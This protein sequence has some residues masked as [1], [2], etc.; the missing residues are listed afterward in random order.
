MKKDS[1][2]LNIKGCHA[3]TVLRL[4]CFM[5]LIHLFYHSAGIIR[6]VLLWLMPMIQMFVWLRHIST[7]GN[8][9]N[10]SLKVVE[11]SGS[12]MRQPT[13]A[14][15]PPTVDSCSY[16]LWKTNDILINHIVFT[17]THRFIAPHIHIILWFCWVGHDTVE[18]FEPQVK[19][20]K[21][22]L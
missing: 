13:N 3:T 9:F 4:R 18:L 7:Q 5:S 22:L 20:N 15:A 1:A 16:C 17:W 6:S 11:T 12:N 19:F 14:T 10:N 21:A 2:F 8:T